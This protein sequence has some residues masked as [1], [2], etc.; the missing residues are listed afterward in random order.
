[1]PAIDQEQNPAASSV[2]LPGF[3]YQRIDVEGV[4]INCAAKGADLPDSGR[5][6]TSR[7]AQSAMVKSTDSVE[8]HT[9][10]RMQ[11]PAMVV[12]MRDDRPWG[13]GAKAGDRSG[14]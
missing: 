1:M 10:Y 7:S 4:T 14:C 9:R 11:R 5:Y 3:D 2:R 13:G 6:R 8:I 12:T